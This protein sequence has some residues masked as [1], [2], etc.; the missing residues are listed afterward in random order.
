MPHSL[1]LSIQ[2]PTYCIFYGKE[3]DT[4][5]HLVFDCEKNYSLWKRLCVWMGFRRVI[6]QWDGAI[7]WI[8]TMARRKFRLAEIST[9]GFSM[10]ITL[11]GGRETKTDSKIH[12]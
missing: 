11:N 7:Q 10:I 3:L 2:V 4:F 12:K 5:E 8:D 6:Q 9:V 1:K